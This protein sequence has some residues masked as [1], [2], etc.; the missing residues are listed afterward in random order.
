MMRWMLV[1]V[2]QLALAAREEESLFLEDNKPRQSFVATAILWSAVVLLSVAAWWWL[3]H[4]SDSPKPHVREVGAEVEARGRA[5][6]R[7]PSGARS[8]SPGGFLLPGD[9]A[10]RQ[11]GCG[12]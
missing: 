12:I 8:T 11:L 4:R 1:A 5:V 6:D 9:R 7:G 10:P 2:A 3:L